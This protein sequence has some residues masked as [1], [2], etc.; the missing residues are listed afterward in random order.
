MKPRGG[1]RG[2][3][4]SPRAEA[5]G[6]VLGTANEGQCVA[7]SDGHQDVCCETRSGMRRI[8]RQYS[9]RAS[10]SISTGT[11]LP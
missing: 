3:R 6:G 1:T 10:S 5:P 11:A 4:G 8:S 9:S 7:I 2:E